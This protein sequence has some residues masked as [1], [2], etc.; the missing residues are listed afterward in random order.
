MNKTS[1]GKTCPAEGPSAA[2]NEGLIYSYEQL[3]QILCLNESISQHQGCSESEIH[4]LLIMR[5]EEKKEE[6][7]N[8]TE[9]DGIHLP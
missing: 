5:D 9:S 7:I 4:V 3:T 1:Q 6:D 8:L 2:F